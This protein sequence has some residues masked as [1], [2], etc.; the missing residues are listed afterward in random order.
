MLSV[1]FVLVTHAESHQQ[2]HSCW[3]ASQSC[4]ITGPSLRWAQ[5]RKL[6]AIFVC[7]TL[8]SWALNHFWWSSSTTCGD[9]LGSVATADCESCRIVFYLLW[10]FFFFLFKPLGYLS[11][12]TFSSIPSS[13]SFC[14]A[15]QHSCHT[16]ICELC[17]RQKHCFWHWF[18]DTGRCHLIFILNFCVVSLWIDECCWSAVMLIA[19]VLCW[20]FSDFFIGGWRHKNTVTWIKCICFCSGQTHNMSPINYYYESINLCNSYKISK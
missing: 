16:G 12:D 7:L 14:D 2:P 1:L 3:A 20:V 6:W 9:D 13:N 11:V 4:R 5:P 18:L 15:L 8:I 17:D 10:V 19:Q